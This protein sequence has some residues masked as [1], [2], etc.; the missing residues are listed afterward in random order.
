MRPQRGLKQPVKKNSGS[1]QQIAGV[2]I[3]HLMQKRAVVRPDLAPPPDVVNE[4]ED[5]ENQV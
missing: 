1:S 2:V 3:S 4:D 5:D